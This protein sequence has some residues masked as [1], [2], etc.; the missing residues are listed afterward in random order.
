MTLF[1]NTEIG[2]RFRQTCENDSGKLM[3][4][5]I[6][7]DGGSMTNGKIAAAEQLGERTLIH[8]RLADNSTLIAQETGDSSLKASD[9]V[10]LNFD[11]SAT[12][13]FD[14][15]GKAYHCN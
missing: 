13:L 7:R 1:W 6:S 9:T 2:N 10:G 5:G 11:L 12:H 3:G 14:E 15:Q 4:A 8:V